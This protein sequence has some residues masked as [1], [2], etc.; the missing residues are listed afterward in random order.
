MH[1]LGGRMLRVLL[2]IVLF[3]QKVRKNTFLL[4]PL[5]KLPGNF[6]LGDCVKVAQLPANFWTYRI[7]EKC[8]VRI[9]TVVYS[10]VLSTY[11]VCLCNIT[12]TTQFTW[13]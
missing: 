2:T 1:T 13:K 11:F 7:D 3:V 12:K 8:K 9:N 6:L 5:S 10:T 4:H